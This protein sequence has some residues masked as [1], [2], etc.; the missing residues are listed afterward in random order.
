MNNPLPLAEACLRNQQPIADCLE[1]ILTKAQSVLEIGSG[2]GQ[3]AVFVCKQLSYLIWQPTELSERV[4][5]VEA[6]RLSENLPNIKP[7]RALDVLQSD[8]QL[9]E[10]YDTV[11]T[12][13]TIHFIGW[14]KVDA[15]FS[16]ASSHLKSSGKFICYGPFNINQQYTSE[17]NKNLDAWLKQRDAESGIKDVSDVKA[18]A[19]SYGLSFIEQIQMPANN[20]ILHFNKR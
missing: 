19:D 15:L 12:A 14:N 17:G 11:F 18:L 5:E 13:N 10:I 6:W 20:L 7:T 1:Q 16:G 9:N 8:W 4:A 3:H 2:T